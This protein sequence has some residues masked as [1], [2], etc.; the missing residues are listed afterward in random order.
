MT[1]SGI[2]QNSVIVYQLREPQL[3]IAHQSSLGEVEGKSGGCTSF[4]KALL[5]QAPWDACH[6]LQCHLYRLKTACYTPV[7]ACAQDKPELME[8]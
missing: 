4:V 7:S 1:V 2:V 6:S 3:Q 5:Q 8:A